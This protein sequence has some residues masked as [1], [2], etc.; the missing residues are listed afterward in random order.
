[1]KPL[2]ENDPSPVTRLLSKINSRSEGENTLDN[3][4]IDITD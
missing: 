4:K 3:D 1:M 2:S